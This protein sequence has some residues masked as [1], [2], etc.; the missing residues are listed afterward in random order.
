[1]SRAS[2]PSTNG[3]QEFYTPR[4]TLYSSATSRR[5]MPR[6]E[7]QYTQRHIQLSDIQKPKELRSGKKAARPSGRSQHHSF[8]SWLSDFLEGMKSKASTQVSDHVPRAHGN[9]PRRSHLSQAISDSDLT[10]S[11]HSTASSANL[12]IREAQQ[13]AR[14]D[15]LD[16]EAQHYSLWGE[17][18]Y[19]Y[20]SLMVKRAKKKAEVARQKHRDARQKTREEKAKMKVAPVPEIDLPEEQMAPAGHPTPSPQLPLPPRLSQQ[21]KEIAPETHLEVTRKPA[22][23]FSKT[24]GEVRK[25]AVKITHLPPV[26]NSVHLQ[27]TAANTRDFHRALE[28]DHKRKSSNIT[29]FG[30][31]MRKPSEP[32]ERLARLPPHIPT[33]LAPRENQRTVAESFHQRNETQWTFIVPKIDEVAG[34]S[35]P[36]LPNV[37]FPERINMEREPQVTVDPRECI[38][39][40]ALNSPKTHYNK[41]GLWLCTIC[42]S[43]RSPREV[44]PTPAIP[45]KATSGRH[46]SRSGPSSRNIPMTIRHMKDESAVFPHES[47]KYCTASLTPTKIFDQGLHVHASGVTSS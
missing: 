24:E 25:H 17:I 23:A 44:P 28:I 16:Y 31:F 40:G 10:N 46:Q 29:T 11:R 34:S 47:C 42:R 32:S 4:P 3:I 2:A 36:I 7:Q 14:E 8:W 33:P 27:Q 37:D 20:K 39:C 38:L 13:A 22:Q 18:L 6:V 35:T 41:Q 19:I 26:H 21:I 30:D 9:T 5:S 43:P 45:R 1:M 12:R 15:Q